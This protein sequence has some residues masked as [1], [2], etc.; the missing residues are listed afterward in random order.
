MQ[1]MA[2][3]LLWQDGDENILE[4]ARAWSEVVARVYVVDLRTRA[5]AYG[6][7]AEA[8]LHYAP[9]RQ[10]TT[11]GTALNRAACLAYEDGMNWIWILDGSAEIPREE[12]Q[13]WSQK[14]LRSTCLYRSDNV[15]GTRKLFCRA[16]CGLLVSVAVTRSLGGWS[17][18]LPAQLVFADFEQRLIAQGGTVEKGIK[19]DDIRSD[20]GLAGIWAG[21]RRRFF[22]DRIKSR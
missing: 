22:A 6:S 13:D 3:G 1:K 5:E 12:L 21:I 4:R 17:P 7:L 14:E 2:L 16:P 15:P 18:V 19:V 20:T 9:F 10:K 8:R 11:L